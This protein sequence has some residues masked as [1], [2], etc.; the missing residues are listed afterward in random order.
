MSYIL[1][2][3]CR[4]LG[5]LVW[6]MFRGGGADAVPLAQWPLYK[7]PQFPVVVLAV[8]RGDTCNVP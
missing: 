6:V 7:G 2:V 4:I 8:A 3:I 5:D 1:R